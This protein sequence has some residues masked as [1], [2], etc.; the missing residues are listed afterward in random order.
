MS[1]WIYESPDKGKTLYKRKK[2]SKKRELVWRA[3]KEFPIDEV[4]LECAEQRAA[5]LEVTVD[6]Y[7][8]EF[9]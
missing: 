8:S 7:I 4:F 6:Y 2:G 3:E 1:D 5:E 9:L